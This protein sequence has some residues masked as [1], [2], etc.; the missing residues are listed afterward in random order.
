[1]GLIAVLKGWCIVSVVLVHSVFGFGVDFGWFV[2]L[3]AFCVVCF[4]Q[5]RGLLVVCGVV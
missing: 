5:L 3:V 2:G 4:L 1:M